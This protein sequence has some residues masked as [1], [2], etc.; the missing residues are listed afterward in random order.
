MYLFECFIGTFFFLLFSECFFETQV[1]QLQ[2]K[3]RYGTCMEQLHN[4]YCS[5]T[6]ILVWRHF[7][8][9]VMY[10]LRNN[11][12]CS[13]GN[14]RCLAAPKSLLHKGPQ[15]LIFCFEFQKYKK[16]SYFSNFDRIWLINELVLTFKAPIEYAEVNEYTNSYSNFYINLYFI[17][18]YNI[19]EQ[20]CCNVAVIL[21]GS[22]HS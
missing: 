5:I 19:I 12:E 15:F 13:L 14:V 17:K 10:Q 21:I 4:E 22:G 3:N 2:N 11:W 1:P 6:T 8:R 18:G 7:Y 9:T 16:Y 20:H